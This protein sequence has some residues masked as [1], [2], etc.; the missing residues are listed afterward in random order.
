MITSL[1]TDGYLTVGDKVNGAGVA[2]FIRSVFFPEMGTGALYRFQMKVVMEAVTSCGNPDG[3]RR[4]MEPLD[5]RE[6]SMV[7]AYFGVIDGVMRS[8]AEVG[9][10]PTH[11]DIGRARAGQILNG[12]IKKMST[13]ASMHLRNSWPWVE[14]PI[15]DLCLRTRAYRPLTNAGIKLVGDLTQ[16]SA[17]FLLGISNFGELALKEVRAKL[18]EIGLSLKDE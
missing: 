11:G 8:K 3:L 16:C 5:N 9:R 4:F 6:R 12:A 14:R 17:V 2:R 15:Q 10:M 1:T 13:R 7:L 18:E